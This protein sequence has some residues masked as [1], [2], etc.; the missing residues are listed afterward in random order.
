MRYFLRKGKG[1]KSQSVV[2]AM[3]VH[4]IEDNTPSM[5]DLYFYAK[6]RQ[7]EQQLLAQRTT[8]SR[9]SDYTDDSLIVIVV[10]RV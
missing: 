1:E 6:V 3:N 7:Y 4:R 8:N 10:V 9:Y 2:I 5:V